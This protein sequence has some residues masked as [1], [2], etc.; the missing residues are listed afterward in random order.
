ML[1]STREKGIKHMGVCMCVH[2]CSA[3]IAKRAGKREKIFSLRTK[4]DKKDG[5]CSGIIG[6][7]K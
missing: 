4:R 5:M 6:G 2:G 1:D 7:A 3:T